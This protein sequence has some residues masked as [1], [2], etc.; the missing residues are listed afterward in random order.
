[1]ALPEDVRV[2]DI[3]RGLVLALRRGEFNEPYLQL[4][5]IGDAD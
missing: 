3:D 1:M 5:R 4:Y 2:L